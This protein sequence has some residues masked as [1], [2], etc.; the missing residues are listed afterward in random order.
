MNVLTILWTICLVS[1]CYGE[2]LRGDPPAAKSAGRVGT[3]LDI[4]NPDR[5]SV[6]VGSGDE[7]DGLTKRVFTPKDSFAIKTVV[8]G[9]VE[10]WKPNRDGEKCELVEA[11][12]K[13]SSI[14]VY[15]KVDTTIGLS[16]KYLE[17]VNESWRNEKE[18]ES[19]VEDVHEGDE[20]PKASESASNTEEVVQE[21]PEP[22]PAT[23]EEEQSPGNSEASQEG[24]FV[25]ESR[26][27]TSRTD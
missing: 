9:G 13:G 22:E 1:L 20:E 6:H 16:L 3:T 10:L 18:E 8:T 26:Y 21:Q 11:Y 23:E 2:E 7:T 27:S 15:L 25:T 5:R 17:K 4:L 24:S 19:P 12:S 14:L